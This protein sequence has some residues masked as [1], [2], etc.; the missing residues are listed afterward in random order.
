MKRT[1]KAR[2]A[3]LGVWVLMIAFARYGGWYEDEMPE[4]FPSLVPSWPAT[5]IVT[6]LIMVVGLRIRKTVWRRLMDWMMEQ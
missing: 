4:G 5:I 2:L 6:G 1:T 3:A